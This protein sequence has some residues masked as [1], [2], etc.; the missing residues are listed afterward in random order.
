MVASL[1]LLSCITLTVASLVTDEYRF[2]D[3]DCRQLLRECEGLKCMIISITNPECFEDQQKRSSKRAS[4]QKIR[5][6]LL[7]S[8]LN[9]MR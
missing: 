9:R 4:R 5:E 2:V 6:I 7:N 3:L 1:L 8:Y